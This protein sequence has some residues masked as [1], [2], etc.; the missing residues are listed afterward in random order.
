[1]NIGAYLET[2]KYILMTATIIAGMLFFL[3]LYL[4]FGKKRRK[5]RWLLLIPFVNIWYVATRILDLITKEDESNS[6]DD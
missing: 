5:D 6:N 3:I 1:M 2:L 4:L